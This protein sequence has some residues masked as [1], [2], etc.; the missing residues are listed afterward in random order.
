MKKYILILS[1]LIATSAS[2][3]VNKRIDFN[4]QIKSARVEQQSLLKNF[5]QELKTQPDHSPDQSEVVEFLNSEI[6]WKS[7]KHNA[8]NN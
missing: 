8:Q 2:A 6:R 5:Q 4:N 1:L 7:P 3:K